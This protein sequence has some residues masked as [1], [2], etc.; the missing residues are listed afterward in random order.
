MRN[1]HLD[2]LR[3]YCL[4][5][6]TIDHL[7]IYGL[8]RITTGTFGIFDAADGFV[9][10]SG[11]VAGS[12]YSWLAETSG[13]TAMMN[14]AWRR[15]RDIYLTYL[16]LFALTRGGPMLLLLH[17]QGWI[18]PYHFWVAAPRSIRMLRLA[19]PWFAPPAGLD[20]LPFYALSLL[21]VPLLIHAWRARKMGLALSLSGG[22]WLLGQPGV[23]VSRTLAYWVNWDP[24]NPFAWQFLFV[25]GLTLGCLPRSQ[26]RG[27]WF[28]SIRT[29]AVVIP[30]FSLFLL[31]RHQRFILG[32]GTYDF[33]RHLNPWWRAK[34]TLGPLRMVDFALFA[35]LMAQV[36]KRYGSWLED[37]LVHRY[38]RFLG[39][40]SLQVFAGSV[41]VCYFLHIT[42]Y[43][44]GLLRSGGAQIALSLAGV[45]SLCIPAY[46][47]LLYRNR[48]R[49]G[50]AAPLRAELKPLSFFSDS[51]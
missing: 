40:H 12:Y 5:V 47:H 30:L 31:W 45:G 33:T 35:C 13:G 8:C 24:C 6:M 18:H 17:G 49:G 20:I 44:F 41:L 21:A 3:G 19:A 7:K 27:D 9:F 4:L 34:P 26:A 23:L 48:F 1:L 22:L 39:Q 10:I 14:R 32:A 29:W 37:T 25:C 38:L 42:F 50:H 15:A 51:L 36:L 2:A 46:L 11:V 43:Q 28:Y 16:V